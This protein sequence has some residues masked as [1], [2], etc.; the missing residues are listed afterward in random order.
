VGVDIQRLTGIS[1]QIEFV[2]QSTFL[3]PSEGSCWTLKVASTTFTKDEIFRNVIAVL[4]AL[5]ARKFVKQKHIQSLNLKLH[6]S[7]A[8]P[9]YNSLPS[10]KLEITAE[11]KV[12]KVKKGEEEKI[13]ADGDE[14]S[15]NQDDLSEDPD[16]NEPEDPHDD[17]LE[18]E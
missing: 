17:E 11:K 16:D 5:V 15:N 12:R 10:Q 6:K 2:K 13:E 3:T 8:L 7:T 9:F 14:V 4:H 18:E 1:R